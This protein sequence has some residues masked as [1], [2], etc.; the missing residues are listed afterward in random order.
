MTTRPYSAK[1]RLRRY[2][3]ILE[4]ILILLAA[5]VF[6][7]VYYL[8]V[9]TFKSPEE[10]ALHPLS[11]PAGLDFGNYAAAWEAMVYPRVLANTAIVTIASVIGIVVF[12]AMAAYGLARRSHTLHRAIFYLFLAGLMV[13]FQ[14]GLVSLYKL[15]N[16]LGLM[17]SLLA[18]IFVNIGSGCTIAIFLF[19]SFIQ[20]SVPLELEE[21]AFMDGCSVPKTFWLIAFPLL[22][23]VIATVAIVSTL[24]VWND[25]MNPLL[26]LQ[27]REH[28]VILL[29]VFRNIGQF[30]VDWTS[31]FP[32]LML[33]VAP[34][35]AFYLFMQKYMIKGVAAG[36]LKG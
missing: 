25:F 4:A 31:L 7:P 3:W 16:A 29:E 2:P 12:S 14:M 35:M 15:I 27:S 32:M 36:A 24:N 23:P 19:H 1:R 8:I 5:V 9:T 10:A 18:V 33:G 11:L 22:K 28:N 21:S 20:S 6:V 17:D 13:P 30:S 34:L 26:F